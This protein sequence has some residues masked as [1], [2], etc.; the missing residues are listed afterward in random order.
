[1]KNRQTA[2]DSGTVTIDS[3]YYELNAHTTVP[4]PIST[5]HRLATIH[6]IADDERQRDRQTTRRAI[7]A[8]VR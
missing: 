4:L 3:L 7:S 2:E 6:F 1:M 8:K 5:T